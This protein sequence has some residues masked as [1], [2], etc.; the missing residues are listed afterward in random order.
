MLDWQSRQSDSERRDF[1]MNLFKRNLLAAMLLA[2][3]GSPAAVLA[4]EG[5]EAPAAAAASEPAVAATPGLRM[6]LM[7]AMRARMHEIMETT[8]PARRKAL[9][10]AQAKDMEVLARMEPPD[11]MGMMMGP[12]GGMMGSGAGMMP[13]WKSD[14]RIRQGEFHARHDDADDQRLDALEKRVDMMQM[15]LQMILNR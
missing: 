14:C 8:D 15:M 5:T 2:A 11:G 4:D 3:L 7:H 9:M 10:E 6:E 1:E 13:G 12:G